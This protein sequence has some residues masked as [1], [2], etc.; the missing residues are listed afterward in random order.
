MCKRT[1]LLGLLAV[2][3]GSLASATTLNWNL[4]TGTD[5]DVATPH[6]YLSTPNGDAIIAYG[7]SSPGT[8]HEVSLYSKND[9]GNEVGLGLDFSGGD[10][11]HEIF[12]GTD[13]IQLNVSALS[14]I[15]S[16]FTFTMESVQST[17]ND[18]WEVLG[19]NTLGVEGSNVL[20]SGTDEGV[21]HT[22]TGN[23][24]GAGTYSYL[25]FVATHGDVLL[26]TVSAVTSTTNTNAPEPATMVLMGLGLAALGTLRR[27]RR[28]N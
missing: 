18:A 14:G 10:S 20:A 2:A 22:L 27:V 23:P 13:F 5:V 6:T 8:T 7:F 26:G 16:S 4:V 1:V 21:A 24:V 9:G 19:S 11:T 17:S 3:F 15:V 12:S 28:K 25:T